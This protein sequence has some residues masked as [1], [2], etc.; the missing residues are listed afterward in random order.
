MATI[1]CWHE[2]LNGGGNRRV[3]AADACAGDEAEQGKARKV[4]S[5]CGR[6]GGDEVD[7]KGD[8]EEALATEPIGQPA[9]Q[10]RPEHCAGE[11]EA[12]GEPDLG[13]GEG[14]TWALS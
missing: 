11:I 13:I 6:G 3:L 7:A 1:S 14:K 12:A 2:F 9:E 10:E 5:E 4:P 8:E